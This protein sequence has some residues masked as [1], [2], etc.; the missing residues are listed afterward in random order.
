MGG[1]SSSSHSGGNYPRS[2]SGYFFTPP[3]PYP[4][5]RRGYH[6]PDPPMFLSHDARGQPLFGEDHRFGDYHDAHP[7]PGNDNL[8]GTVTVN[9]STDHNLNMNGDHHHSPHRAPR[10]S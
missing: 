10:P 2:K 8:N 1:S 7:V 4:D 9:E 6:S 5:L 3:L